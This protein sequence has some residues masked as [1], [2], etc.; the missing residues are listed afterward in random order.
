MPPAPGVGIVA[1]LRDDVG[2][3]LVLEQGDLVLEPQLPFLESGEL[4]LVRRRHGAE[5]FDRRIEIA[6]LEPQPHQVRGRA[7][8]RAVVHASPQAALL[9]R[10]ETGYE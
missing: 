4:E 8:V 5:R 2:D 6:M 3:E 9:S 1:R 7:D 10:A